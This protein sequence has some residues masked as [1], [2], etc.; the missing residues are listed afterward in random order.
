[1]LAAKGHWQ[2][3]S[4]TAAARA[5]RFDD[6]EGKPWTASLAIEPPTE[7]RREYV[8]KLGVARVE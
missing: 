7:S 1:V 4:A 2:R 8:V 3:V 5:W 6:E